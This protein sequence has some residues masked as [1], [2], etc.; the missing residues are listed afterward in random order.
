MFL[1]GLATAFVL[2]F[3]FPETVHQVEKVYKEELKID[4][5]EDEM[6]AYNASLFCWIQCLAQGLGPVFF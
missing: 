5:D 4:Y 1:V 6:H 2:T 3:A